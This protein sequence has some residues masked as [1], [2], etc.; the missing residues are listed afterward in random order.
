M[1]AIAAVLPYG[2]DG[3]DPVGLELLWIVAPV[4]GAVV[5]ILLL[6]LIIVFIRYYAQI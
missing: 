6:V 2:A 3:S 5:L 1:D 4:C